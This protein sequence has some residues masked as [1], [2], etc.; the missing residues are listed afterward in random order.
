MKK[1][2][3]AGRC[4]TFFLSVVL[5]SAAVF[6]CK[7]DSEDR[8]KPKTITD[9]INANDQ[10]SILREIVLYSEMSDALR[11]DNLTFF[12]PDNNAFGKANIFSSS[13]I[14]T[15]K[16]SAKL[17]VQNHIIPKKVITYANLKVGIEKS[18]NNKDLSITKTDSI[19]AINKSDI[20]IKDVNAANGII[21]VIDSLVVR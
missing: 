15:T 12:A 17:F 2:R 20:V 7:E 5:L 1:N 11:G 21:H 6:S 19:V 10:F 13:V 3:F 8:I 16:A 18:I 14:T 4:V 9:V